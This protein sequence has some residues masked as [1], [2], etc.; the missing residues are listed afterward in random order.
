MKSFKTVKLVISDLNSNDQEFNFGVSSNFGLVTSRSAF[1]SDFSSFDDEQITEDGASVDTE[2]Y[3]VNEAARLK[4]SI[5][6][7]SIKA[8]RIL[9]E[10]KVSPDDMSSDLINAVASQI[11]CLD[12]SPNSN[13]GDGLHDTSVIVTVQRLTQ[14]GNWKNVSG[15][16]FFDISDLFDL[17]NNGVPCNFSV[18]DSEGSTEEKVIVAMKY[19]GFS[20]VYNYSYVDQDS[21]EMVFKSQDQRFVVKSKLLKAGV[22]I[23]DQRLE[24]TVAPFFSKYDLLTEEVYSDISYYG[25]DNVVDFNNGVVIIPSSQDESNGD[26]ANADFDNG[27][28]TGTCIATTSMMSDEM[29]D[30]TI[31]LNR[32]EEARLNAITIATRRESF[33]KKDIKALNDQELMNSVLGNVVRELAP[34][35]WS[36]MKDAKLQSAVNAKL[37]EYSSQAAELM[38]VVEAFKRVDGKCFAYTSWS[39]LNALVKNNANQK[40][41]SQVRAEILVDIA[42]LNKGLLKVSDIDAEVV[43]EIYE[44]AKLGGR[45]SLAWITNVAVAKEVKVKAALFCNVKC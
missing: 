4:K 10:A 33:N 7:E 27:I 29:T 43:A 16:F 2:E 44:A 17:D 36:A 11:V 38:Q 28:L 12:E 19:Y 21:G 26:A 22:T 1:M 31:A 24:A 40:F 18:V 5:A 34:V 41:K 35:T 23:A 39:N 6:I 3:L 13:G 45:N 14:N 30:A 42:N 15:N 8:K 9:I 32:S 25:Y 37:Q 20:T